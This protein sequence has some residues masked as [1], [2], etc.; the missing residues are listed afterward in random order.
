LPRAPEY[1]IGPYGNGVKGHPHRL[2]LAG[3]N[4]TQAYEQHR[5]FDQG[6]KITAG[7]EN[8]K[9]QREIVLRQALRPRTPAP[10]K[11]GGGKAGSLSLPL[12]NMCKSP[13]KKSETRI[14]VTGMATK[15]NGKGR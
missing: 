4:L 13:G 2:R 15:I 6:D 1:T 11:D 10:K 7:E 12:C 5:H 3:A 14:P 9:S 8:K